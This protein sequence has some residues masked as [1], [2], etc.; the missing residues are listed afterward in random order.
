M[1]APDD[2]THIGEYPYEP[3]AALVYCDLFG[4]RVDERI[5]RLLKKELNAWWRCD[6]SCRGCNRRW[7]R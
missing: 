7:L 3:H 6:L 5:C 4:D 2:V 1:S